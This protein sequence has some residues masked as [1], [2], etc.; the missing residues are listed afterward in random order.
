MNLNNNITAVVHLLQLPEIDDIQGI[1]VV[2]DD[3]IQKIDA[4]QQW[5]IWSLLIEN[6]FES[7]PS[8]YGEFLSDEQF[9]VMEHICDS[10]CSH[11]VIPFWFCCLLN[12][13]KSAFSLAKKYWW[14]FVRLDTFV[15]SVERLS[16]GIQIHPQPEDIKKY[17]LDAWAENIELWVDVQVKHTKMLE[18]KT[19]Q[20]SIEQ[21]E[22]YGVEWIIITG[23][24]TGKSPTLDLV[25]EAQKRIKN[26]CLLIG[27]GITDQNI[28]K[29]SSYVDWYI[30][31]SYFYN[32][33]WTTISVKKVDS[34]TN[35]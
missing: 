2:I 1:K 9:Q 32:D 20:Q 8:P 27:S 31:W 11:I 25:W 29:F 28:K 21:A 30:V 15:D 35:W 17:Q 26:S 18:E 12:D 6:D 10:I 24:R 4:F 5:W 34:L 14:S 16:D 22:S 3:A 23:D 13:Y 19:L 33:D 7:S